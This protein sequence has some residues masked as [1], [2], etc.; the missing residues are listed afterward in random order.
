M[1]NAEGRRVRQ[2]FIAGQG[3]KMVAADYSQIELRIMAHLSEDPSL[4]AAFADL[5]CDCF[6]VPPGPGFLGGTLPRLF[7]IFPPL[8]PP[9]RPLF[10]L[11]L[12]RSPEVDDVCS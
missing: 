9:P 2:A 8:V 1:R 11:P 6:F 3:K 12:P 7:G 5:N 10:G 4:V